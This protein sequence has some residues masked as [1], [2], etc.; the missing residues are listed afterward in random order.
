MRRIWLVIFMLLAVAWCLAQPRQPAILPVPA[1]QPAAIAAST[2]P[3]RAQID[4]LLRQLGDDHWKLRQEAQDKLVR[5]GEDVIVDLQKLQQETTEEEVRTRAEAALREIR[6]NIEDGPTQITLH[7]KDAD[8][9][10]VF[11]DISKQAKVRIGFENQPWPQGLPTVSINVDRQPFWLVMKEICDKTGIGPYPYY[12]QNRD[13]ISLMQGTNFGRYPG[14]MNKCFYITP[15]GCQRNHSIDFANPQGASIHFSLQI[16]IYVDPKLRTLRSYQM[17]VDSIVDENGN[18]LYNGPRGTENASYWNGGSFRRDMSVQ[19]SYQPNQGKKIARLK[20]STRFVVITKIERWELSDI[21]TARNITKDVPFGKCIVKQVT[22]KS[23]QNYE[24]QVALENPPAM[25]AQAEVAGEHSTVQQSIRLEDANGRSWYSQGGS[26][27]SSNARRDF[28]FTY[29]RQS[30]GRDGPGIPAKL[31]W[32]IPIETKD[33]S[34]PI[35]FR[36]L[37][38]P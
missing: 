35:D 17:A 6:A 13:T 24:I 37:P 1:T 16:A 28:T 20:G 19:L 21:L 2:R 30:S 25:A 3:T 33:V 27:S 26:G 7:V 22:K 4:A 23:D 9:R 10:K 8:L 12:S 11:E 38:L 31:V 14:V 34:V 32:E 36:D 18:S 5:L 29:Y 15:I